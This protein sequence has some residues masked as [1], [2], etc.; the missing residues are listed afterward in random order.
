MQITWTLNDKMISSHGGIS[1]IPIGTR[2]SLLT[3]ASV[4]ALHAG[5]FTCSAKNKAGTSSH[6]ATLVI[7]GTIII[8][9]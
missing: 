9:F 1:T 7:N 3:I 8:L 6:S 4:E 5:K 2:T